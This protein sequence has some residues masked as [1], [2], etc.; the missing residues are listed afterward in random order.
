MIVNRLSTILG[1]RRMSVAELAR[2]AGLTY[3]VA[4]GMYSGETQRYDAPVL[5][6]LCQ[7]LGVQVG[8][9]LVYVPDEESDR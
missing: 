7:A 2:R 9:L 1:E 4:H 3:S 8:D 5:D 6:K